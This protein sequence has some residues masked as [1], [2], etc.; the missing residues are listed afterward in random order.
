MFRKT[1]IVGLA[2]FHGGS[3]TAVW[4]LHANF[5]S[6]RYPSMRERLE[7]SRPREIQQPAT[8]SITV[9]EGGS[10][11]SPLSYILLSL[12]P[13]GLTFTRMFCS[14]YSVHSLECSIF[15][16]SRCVQ[17]CFGLRGPPRYSS[18]HNTNNIL[19]HC[20]VS[21]RCSGYPSHTRAH[22]TRSP[23]GESRIR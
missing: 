2:A 21:I 7:E 18:Q 13:E 22:H 12:K 16:C 5:R 9:E 8:D 10:E 15:N 19:F 1:N 17:H 14:L 4:P 3:L 23:T 11:S 6:I 20:R